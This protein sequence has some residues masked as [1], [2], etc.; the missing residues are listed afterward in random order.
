MRLSLDGRIALVTGASRGIGRAAALELAR[1][2]AHVIALARTQGA[3]ENLDDAIRSEGNEATL[4]PCDLKDFEA[5]DRLG[6]AIF[7]RW[8]KL[9]IFIGNAGVL[10]P[11]TPLAHMDPE[12]WE[13]VFAVNVTANWRLIRSL[14]PLLRLAEAGRVVF[15][16]SSAGHAADLK[17]YWGHSAVTKAALEA[18]ARTYAAETKNVSRVRV[19]AVNPGPIRTRMRAAAMPGEDPMSLRA[20]EDLAPK[21]LMFCTLEW[22]QTGKLYDFPTDRVL[23]FM[24][25][26]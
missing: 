16:S 12:R 5:L 13:E 26:A 8:G 19:M 9:D 24:P 17:P 7:E 14:D 11:L 23:S 1:S 3:L 21:I 6:A 25:P 20:P 22:T 2:G 10:G 4:V 15:I 18:L